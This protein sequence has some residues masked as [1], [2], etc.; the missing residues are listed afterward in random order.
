VSIHAKPFSLQRH[1]DLTRMDRWRIQENF[2]RDR[3]VHRGILYALARQSK[4]CTS[5]EIFAIGL[6]P[7]V[8]A[9]VSHSGRILP[10]ARFCLDPTSKSVFKKRS[11]E[12]TGERPRS[13]TFCAVWTGL[14]P[15][16]DPKPPY[17]L[18]M[19][20][21]SSSHPINLMNLM[22]FWFESSLILPIARILLLAV[23]PPIKSTLPGPPS[24]PVFALFSTLGKFV[25]DLDLPQQTQQSPNRSAAVPWALLTPGE[26]LVGHL[27][28][29]QLEA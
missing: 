4:P 11:D 25:T 20:A 15:A 28:K 3:P 22:P 12:K 1:V 2:K 23:V 5:P 10:Q 16:P 19:P 13:Q 18:P 26:W 9:V 8:W 21:W 6:S 24:L 17:R 27:G 14:L 7:P 29:Q